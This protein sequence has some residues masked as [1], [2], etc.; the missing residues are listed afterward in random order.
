MPEETPSAGLTV[1]LPAQ[2][3]DVTV[4]HTVSGTNTHKLV[5]DYINVYTLSYEYS[6]NVFLD[7]SAA[8][9][10]NDGPEEDWYLFEERGQ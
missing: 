7:K 6:N 2:A 10:V 1:E 3:D 5:Q 8:L 4:S 9:I